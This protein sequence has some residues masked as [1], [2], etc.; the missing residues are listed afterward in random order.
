MPLLAE[1]AITPDVFDVA[2]YT[3]EEVCGLHL[4]AIREPMLTDGLVRDL[5]DGEWRRLFA[6][7][8]RAW[9]RRG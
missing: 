2:S 5:R 4:E 9:H 6:N 7:D 3:S 8:A 1:Y